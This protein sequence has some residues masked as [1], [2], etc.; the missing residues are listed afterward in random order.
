MRTKYR[1]IRMDRASDDG[2]AIW[3]AA[4]RADAAFLMTG[5]ESGRGVI[6]MPRSIVTC[7]T[8]PS[9]VSFDRKRLN[10]KRYVSGDIRYF[11]AVAPTK[12]NMIIGYNS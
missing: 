1:S 9:L 4:P 10:N 6:K 3:P 8:E 12:K 11:S 5:I 2:R 7:P